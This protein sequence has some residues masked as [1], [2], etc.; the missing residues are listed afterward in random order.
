MFFGCVCLLSRDKK[1]RRL[2]EEAYA[3][4]RKRPKGAQRTFDFLVPIYRSLYTE[5]RKLVNETRSYE[6]AELQVVKRGDFNI[7]KSNC[8]QVTYV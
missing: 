6:T 1:A 5:D 7:H 3:N 8:L 2:A 4:G